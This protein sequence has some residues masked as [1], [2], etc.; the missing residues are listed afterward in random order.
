MGM[1]FKDICNSEKYKYVRKTMDERGRIRWV[2]SGLGAVGSSFD[3]ER[4]AAK[5]ADLKLI[6]QGKEPVNILVRK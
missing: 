4:S 6:E 3:N 1:R 2:V 5:R